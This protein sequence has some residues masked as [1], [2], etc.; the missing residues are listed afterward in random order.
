MLVKKTVNNGKHD[1]VV[2]VFLMV[3][4]QAQDTLLLNMRQTDS[5]FLSNN[6]ILLVSNAGLKPCTSVQGL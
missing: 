3:V 2:L 1:Q 5:L 6:L 4:D